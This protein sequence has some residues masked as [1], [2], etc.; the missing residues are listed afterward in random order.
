MHEPQNE[1][2]QDLKDRLRAATLENVEVVVISFLNKGPGPVFDGIDFLELTQG[3]FEQRFFK[4]KDN[5]NEKIKIFIKLCFLHLLKDVKSASNRELVIKQILTR[6]PTI[7]IALS[8]KKSFGVIKTIEIN[9]ISFETKKL[10]FSSVKTEKDSYNDYLKIINFSNQE[11]INLIDEGFFS[12]NNIQDRLLGYI[13]E[14][15]NSSEGDADRNAVIAKLFEKFTPP[16]KLPDQFYKRELSDISFEI[17]CI[18]LQ[19]AVNQNSH[20][21]QYL[22]NIAFSHEEFIQ[23]LGLPSSGIKRRN[24]L[25]FFIIH[26]L[27]S[28]HI[29]DR[30]AV[31]QKILEKPLD[32]FFYDQ[33]IANFDGIN[34]ET[35]KQLLLCAIRDC[36]GDDP[37][38]R[39]NPSLFTSL[40]EKIKLMTFPDFSSVENPQNILP[41]IGKNLLD[42]VLKKEAFENR[43]EVIGNI[44]SVFKP[45]F[46]Y[47]ALINFRDLQVKT[48]KALLNS[49][50]ENLSQ[51]NHTDFISFLQEIDLTDLDGISYLENKT[52]AE[53]CFNY[54]L[55][56]TAF[57]DRDSEINKI[58]NRHKHIFHYDENIP[59]DGLK[60]E[61]KKNLLLNLYFQSEN[62]KIKGFLEKVN[63]SNQEFMSCL[64]EILRPEDNPSSFKLNSLKMLSSCL[65]Y[66]LK[67]SYS[68][69]EIP[70]RNELIR[71]I[72]QSQESE[73]RFRYDSNMSFDGISE[74]IKK[75]LFEHAMNEEPIENNFQG[76]LENIALTNFDDINFDKKNKQCI[77]VFFKYIVENHAKTENIFQLIKKLLK[78]GAKLPENLPD[79][80]LQNSPENVL[81]L[82]CDAASKE[83]D[84]R[85]IKSIINKSKLTPF[86][87]KLT[88]SLLA[89]LINVV[90]LG[91]PFIYASYQFFNKY[92]QLN[93]PKLKPITRV[94]E[95][96]ENNPEMKLDHLSSVRFFLSAYQARINKTSGVGE[97]TIADISASIGSEKNDDV[98]LVSSFKNFF[99]ILSNR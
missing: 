72:F 6:W 45:S 1:K 79:S 76:F 27:K 19:Q 2:N 90:T 80:F 39:P 18:L 60:Y 13:L 49:L 59:I 51:T 32:C 98:G 23:Y 12:D 84:T 38:Y 20:V 68:T 10:L 85:A 97:P 86:V 64:E 78:L 16:P 41:F 3:I 69:N 61:T 8:G 36:K 91:I 4:K 25:Q 43:D 63:F 42:Y 57:T 56:N 21:L 53:Y 82:L 47:N 52:I 34:E 89:L 15:T 31:I 9:D 67:K 94:S 40:L 11:L 50:I 37:L 96:N 88:K 71:T 73:L 44:L 30:N 70:D 46:S 29:A 77:S 35:K 99:K 62:K 7:F 92:K 24:I 93:D 65:S 14:K 81:R 26:A 28:P 54:I 48:K 66:I 33:S 83:N 95:Q 5:E 55:R 75:Q 74:K 17:K 87:N 22:E 58:L